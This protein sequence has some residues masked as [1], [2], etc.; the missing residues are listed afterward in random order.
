VL[1]DEPTVQASRVTYAAGAVEPAGTHSYDVV[2]V[3]LNRG[4]I[5]LDIPG[6]PDP[7]WQPG[8][9]I[10]I[11]RG[12]EHRLVNVGKTPIEFIVLRIP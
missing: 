10:F 8:S 5:K 7:Q 12:T 3:P 6:K 1:V 4:V 9:A 11:K 2:I